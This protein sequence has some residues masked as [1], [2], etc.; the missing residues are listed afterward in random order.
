MEIQL[1]TN[2]IVWVTHLEV[3]FIGKVVSKTKCSL[4]QC[5]T[6]AERSNVNLV[7]L[8]VSVAIVS[9]DQTF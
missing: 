7:L 3:Q 6:L 9:L 4:T 1:K 8:Y 2:S 5:L